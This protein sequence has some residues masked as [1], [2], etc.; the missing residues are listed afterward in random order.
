MSAVEPVELP[1]GRYRLRPATE[2]DVDAAVALAADPDIRQWYSTGVV[3]RESARAWLRRGADWSDG[4]HATWVV[5]DE[6]DRLV[7]IFSMVRIDRI[8][9]MTALMSYRTAPWARRRGV[10]TSAL[11]AAT[12][13]AAGAL[14]LERLE[15]LHAVANPGSCRVAERAGYRL[16]GVC[17]KGFRDDEGRRWDSHLHARLADDPEPGTAGA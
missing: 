16:E 11:V 7:G 15:L 14:G 13:W 5:A 17:R 2:A 1:A 3:D 8:D 12:R 9:Q 10:A 4:D 6:V